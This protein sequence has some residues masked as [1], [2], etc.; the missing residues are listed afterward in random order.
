MHANLT[1]LLHRASQVVDARFARELPA[2]WSATPTQAT[3]LAA[4]GASEECSQTEIV[5][6]T[7][8][9][10][11]TVAEVVRRLAWR[12]LLARKRSKHDSR[13]Y[14]VT[15]TKDGRDLLEQVARTRAHAEA[16]V[17]GSLSAEKQQQLIALL[18][19]LVA[20]QGDGLA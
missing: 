3:V 5:R 13:A 11:S 1:A 9:D 17:L 12:G 15:I 2:R 19:E 7:G 6:A 20:A 10:R 4:V 8:V 16:T 18:D 14:Q